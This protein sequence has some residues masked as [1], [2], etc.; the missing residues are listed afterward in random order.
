MLEIGSIVWGVRDASKFTEVVRFWCE[1]L[2]YEPAREPGSDFA[3]IVPKN[4]RAGQQMSIDV[5][6]AV[7]GGTQNR[8]R[9][10]LDLYASDQG[11]EVGRLLSIGATRPERTYPT[12]ADYIILEDPDGN[13][14]CVI[15][16]GD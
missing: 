11:A 1:A 6:S 3:I 15:D 2:D 5:V 13:A 16:K 12:G 7:D 10:H 9:H 8:T 14:F 4:G